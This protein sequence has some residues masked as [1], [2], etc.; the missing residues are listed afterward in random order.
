MA[1]TREYQLADA[2]ELIAQANHY[3]VGLVEGVTD[4]ERDE[5][6]Q[7]LVER[8]NNI[9]RGR[10]WRRLEFALDLLERDRER[11]LRVRL[12]AWEG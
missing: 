6:E 3:M 5:A 7:V 11:S 12:V 1:Q 9:P 8:Q 10:R 4:D 2:Y